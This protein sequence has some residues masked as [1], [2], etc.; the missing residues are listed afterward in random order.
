MPIMLL[1]D[2]AR[3][4]QIMGSWTSHK[5]LSSDEVDIIVRMIAQ[6]ITEGRRHGFEL[7]GAEW[8]TDS[9]DHVNEL[10][11]ARRAKS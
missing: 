8:P 9:K 7:A 10:K 6:G 5:G 1:Y 4:R 3:A 11:D 2:L